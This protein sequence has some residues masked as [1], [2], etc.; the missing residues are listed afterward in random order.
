[1]EVLCY[2]KLYIR[3]IDKLRQTVFVKKIILKFPAKKAPPTY[4]QQKQKKT[5]NLNV[6]NVTQYL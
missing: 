1:M 5:A 6:S 2:G 4:Q 3:K